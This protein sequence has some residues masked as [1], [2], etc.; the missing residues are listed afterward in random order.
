[1]KTCNTCACNRVCDHYRHGWET[2]GNWV[3]KW[4]SVEDR[5]PE[6][7]DTLVLAITNGKPAENITLD[8]AY[9]FAGYSKECGWWIEEY[10]AWENACVT[11]WMPLPEPPTAGPK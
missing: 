7:S 3:P 6:D 1:M 4:I 9:Q 5:L 2:C 8:A 10:P 11:H